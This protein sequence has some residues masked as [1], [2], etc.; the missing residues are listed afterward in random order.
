MLRN[1]A[2]NRM[3][4]FKNLISLLESPNK[5]NFSLGLVVA[6]NYKEEVFE[7]FGC[8][9]EE[10]EELAEFL[11]ENNVW[12]PGTPLFGIIYLSLF[13]NNLA[14]LPKSFCLLKNL[15]HLSLVN[16]TSYHIP[17]EICNLINLKYLYLAKNQLQDLPVEIG[18]LIKLESLYLQNN[19]LQAI[20][21]EI[22]NMTKLKRL[23]LTNNQISESEIANIKKMLTNCNVIT[24]EI[25]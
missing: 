15:Q 23:D 16:C 1:H 12:N 14:E 6:Q 9:L 22:G 19:Q 25:K 11:K 3:N 24:K 8:E 10:I 21:A 13:N 20:P 17:K 5:E 7:Y 4:E 18:N 2:R